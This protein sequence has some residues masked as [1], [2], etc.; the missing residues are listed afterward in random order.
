MCEWVVCGCVG[1]AIVCG[2]WLCEYGLW[3][4]VV[5]DCVWCVVVAVCE[6]VVVCMCAGVFVS[7]VITYFS[8]IL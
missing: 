8:K 6:C 3:L 4:C 2:V 1:Y 7:K 5:C